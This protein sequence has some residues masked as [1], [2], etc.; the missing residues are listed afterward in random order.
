MKKIVRFSVFFLLFGFYNCFSQSIWI[1]QYSGTSNVFRYVQFLDSQ[2]GW[3]TGWYGATVKTTNGGT[4]WVPLNTGTSTC[5]TSVFFVNNLTGWLSGGSMADG[6]AYIQK[7]TNGGNTWFNVHSSNLGLVFRTVFVSQNTGYSV[8]S[9]GFIMKSTDGGSGWSILYSNSNN[10]YT[11]CFFVDIN[12]GWVIG[13]NGVILKT[14]NGGSSFVSQASGTNSNLEGIHFISSNTGFV[15]SSLGNLLKTTNGGTNWTNKLTGSYLWL[16]SVYFANN[17]TGWL[18]GG[19]VMFL[20][21]IKA[22]SVSQ[23]L[24]STDCGE[25]WMQQSS[26]TSSFLCSVTFA[27]SQTGWAVGSNGTILKTTNGGAV[28]VQNIS[29]EKPSKIFLNQNYPNPFNP[30]T[31]IRLG[32]PF[33][34]NIKLNVFDVNGRL[35]ENLY[36]GN[37][38]AGAFEFKWDAANFS[39]GI[40]FA[41]LESEGY[42]EIKKMTLIK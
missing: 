16:N 41:K 36:D 4:N 42:S 13:D 10:I 35:V 32:I 5:F 3:A 38:T 20:D 39:S 2:T 9:K 1:S 27:N 21:N 37:I 8:T 40:Y 17:N 31:F 11:N 24:K 15:S 30:V 18:T 7:T 23:I 19:D 28:F 14:T 12:T 22:N 6:I 25:T 34:S 26:P 29:S 33:S